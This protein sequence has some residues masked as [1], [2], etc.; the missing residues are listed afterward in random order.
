MIMSNDINTALM[1]EGIFGVSIGKRVLNF[2]LLFKF[3][4]NM[5]RQM[6]MFY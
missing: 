5:P 2:V 3:T 1:Y 6:V 4:Y